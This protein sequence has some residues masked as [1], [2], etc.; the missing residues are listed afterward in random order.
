MLRQEHDLALQYVK[1]YPYNLI[2]IYINDSNT[3][4]INL[5]QQNSIHVGP[6]KLGDT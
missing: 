2:Y 3:W 6:I 4:F 1:W 5:P